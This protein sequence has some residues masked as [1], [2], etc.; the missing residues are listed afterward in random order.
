LNS[1]MSAASADLATY[2][3]GGPATLKAAVSELLG[4]RIHYFAAIDMEGMRQVVDTLG[5]VDV[6][7]ERAISD[8]GY[9]DTLTGATGLVIQAGRQH[10]DGATALG[11][12]RSR[13]SAGEN[14]FTRAERQ[15][16]LLTAIAA[17]LTAGNLLTALP[18]LLDAVRDN[19]A[20][21]IPS[22]R[23]SSIAAELEEARLGNVE[24]VVLTPEDGYVTVDAAS[25]AG[26]VLYPNPEA[27]HALGD[28]IFADGSSATPTSTATPVP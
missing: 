9:K 20:T 7:V 23:I 1:L 25:A 16:Q 28:R 24:R 15:Q 10:L 14:D 26:Y 18:G 22:S 17:K 5:G 11:Y 21:D 13:K 8:P 12:A 3:L 2:P 19:V 27:I 6:T 4:T